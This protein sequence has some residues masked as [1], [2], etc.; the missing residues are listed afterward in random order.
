MRL[1]EVARLNTTSSRAR[2]AVVTAVV[3]AVMATTCAAA[4][5]GGVP[6][7]QLLAL[8]DSVAAGH[9][10]GPDD[11]SSAYPNLV[12]MQRGY[13]VHNYA[14]SGACVASPFEVAPFA[15][16]RD[17]P[18]DCPRSG[19]VVDQLARAKADH[20]VPAVITLTVG[21]NDVRFADCVASA[22][23]FGSDSDPCAGSP[24]FATR[25]NALLH[26]L[27]GLLATITAQYPS[28][29]VILT[30]YYNPLPAVDPSRPACRVFY[31][32]A[33]ANDL[34]GTAEQF[35]RGH[36]DAAA[37]D[38][39][40]SIYTQ[41]ASFVAGLDASIQ[42]AARLSGVQSVAL[43]FSGHDLC[44]EYENY[45]PWVFAPDAAATLTIGGKVLSLG[46]SHSNTFS[47]TAKDT[48][49]CDASEPGGS[50]P[51]KGWNPS[52]PVGGVEATLHDIHWN[53]NGSP[54]PNAAGQ[55]AIAAQVAAQVKPW[56]SS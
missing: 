49:T 28:A 40:A 43:D 52:S 31:Y 9:G 41:A 54:H 35:A 18:T 48:C 10:L 19:N 51:S 53:A 26:N 14:V 5:P 39:Q 45:V 44:G 4:A 56:P 50:V 32:A 46:A 27:Q 1:E 22:T 15:V 47:V 8:G 16:D 24:R 21:A 20:V 7:N 33:A 34:V 55:V 38:Y 2:V 13:E 36:M 25:Q 6:G 3:V 11:N 17:T 12:G 29:Q 37:R 23:G 30:Q 42:T